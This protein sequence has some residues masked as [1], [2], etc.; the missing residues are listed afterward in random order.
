M[1]I[2]FIIKIIKFIMKYFVIFVASNRYMPSTLNIIIIE[3]WNHSL[4]MDRKYCVQKLQNIKMANLPPYIE[5][6][7][8]NKMARLERKGT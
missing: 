2:I 6:F 5:Q 4:S 1:L 8:T 3:Y 7:I